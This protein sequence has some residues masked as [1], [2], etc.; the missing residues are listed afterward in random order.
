MGK[1]IIKTGKDGQRYFNLVAGNGE[2]ILSSEGYAALAGCKKGIASVMKNGTDKT[3]F[4]KKT[5]KNGKFFF[6]LHA[7]N[8]QVIGKSE[9]Y[10]TERACDNGIASVMRNAGTA[11][12][13]FQKI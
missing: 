4:E 6:T 10:E 2:A 1:F 13:E 5:A 11:T 7:V 9:M 3:K 8:K 12:I